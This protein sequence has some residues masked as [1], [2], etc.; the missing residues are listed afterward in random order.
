MQGQ[1]DNLVRQ[2]VKS[3]PEIKRVLDLGC[4]N[5]RLAASLANENY[6]VVGVDASETG[7][8]IARKTYA[9]P[10][11]AFE[12]ARIDAS[13]ND[14]FAGKQF[15]LVVSCDVIEHLYLPRALLCA[16]R[17]LLRPGG[18]LLLTTPY[19]GWLKNVVISV[20][21]K[22]DAHHTV[23]WDGGHIKFFSVRTLRDMV[24]DHGFDV[25]K[26]RFFGR[27]PYLRKNMICI[28]QKPGEHSVS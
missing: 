18:H 4:G 24:H 17:D 19:H 8:E 26:F 20:T 12:C 1:L 23:G 9:R 6:V 7:I 22:W 10:N 13:L 28:A 25:V 11:L 27:L 14:K 3:L 2:E 16:A 21:G 15:D 5:G